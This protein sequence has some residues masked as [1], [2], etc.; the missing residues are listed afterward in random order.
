MEKGTAIG[1]VRGLGPSR[2]GAHHWLQERASSLAAFGLCLFL[3][4]AVLGLGDLS[5]AKVHDWIS[6]PIPATAVALLVIVLFWHTRLGLQVLI[7]DYVHT[8]ANKVACLLLNTTFTWGGTAFG[9]MCIARLAL[10]AK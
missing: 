6:G 10:G 8:P 9:L 5:Y 1:R 3:I 7:E 2:S 4:F